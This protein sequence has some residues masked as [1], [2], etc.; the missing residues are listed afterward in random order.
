M[1]PLAQL[2]FLKAWALF[3]LIIPWGLVLS[4]LALLGVVCL[5]VWLIV[6]TQTD[7]QT[8]PKQCQ[9]SAVGVIFG[10][11]KF[12]RGGGDNLH[13]KYR[14]QLAA[15]LWH[16]GRIKHLLVSGDNHTRYYNEPITMWKDLQTLGIPRH[17][18]TLDYAGFSTFDTLA[19]ARE[20]FQLERM[21]LVTQAYHLPRALFIARQLGL[22]AQGCAAQDPPRAQW[23]PVMLREI[24][25]RTA[26]FGDL[27]LWS[28]QPYF[29]GEPVPIA[30][31][32][33]EPLLETKSSANPAPEN[34]Q[35]NSP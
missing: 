29:L 26:M 2:C 4:I 5:N 30:I 10:T 17:A 18:M 1:K 31:S 15:S 3:K 13:Y 19:R 34:R 9:A 35:K 11:S 23:W 14:L 28:R 12:L 8:D 20:V 21:L 25:A 27:Y 33:D 7:W 22:D 32:E 16:Q 24:A 6:V